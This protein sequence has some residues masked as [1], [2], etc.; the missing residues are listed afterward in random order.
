VPR[1]SAFLLRIF[2]TRA[3][4][5]E[6]PA[7]PIPGTGTLPARAGAAVSSC[8]TA[9]IMASDSNNGSAA[10]SGF[11]DV[12]KPACSAPIGSTTAPQDKE[13]GRV[14]SHVRGIQTP[15]LSP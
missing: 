3:P 6:P 5:F 14:V 8:S 10:L 7:R 15:R 1:R 2:E 4:R 13:V 11:G 9:M 12:T